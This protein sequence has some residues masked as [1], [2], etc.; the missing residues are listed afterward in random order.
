MV[1]PSDQTSNSFDFVSKPLIKSSKHEEN[2]NLSHGFFE[3]NSKMLKP[4]STSLGSAAL[5]LH[6]ANLII[7]IEKMIRSPQL[8]GVDAGDD[9]H[10]MLPNSIRSL[11]RHRLKGIGFTASD[12]VLAGEWREALGKI[13]GWLLLITIGT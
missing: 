12:P 1:H 13:L 6:Y 2:N 10:M 11:L 3:M 7:V 8:V 9:I 5:A 4:S